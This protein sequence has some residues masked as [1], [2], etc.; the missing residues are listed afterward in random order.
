VWPVPAK[1]LRRFGCAD[2]LGLKIF[3]LLWREV[4]GR[5]VHKQ[6]CGGQVSLGGSCERNPELDFGLLHPLALA[7]VGDND[8]F[9]VNRL[10]D[11]SGIPQCPDFFWSPAR[12]GRLPL[13][14]PGRDGRFFVAD[15][16]GLFRLTG[17]WSA[18]SPLRFRGTACR[19]T[20]GWHPRPSGSAS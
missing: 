4:L 8:L 16:I 5:H 2:Q 7:V 10:E 1:P 15:L 17:H 3:A 9:I 6:S 20:F 13:F 18:P 14:E 12:I 19:L 11:G